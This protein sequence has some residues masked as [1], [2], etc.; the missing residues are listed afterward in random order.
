MCSSNLE[1]FWK[2][3][4]KDREVLLLLFFIIFNLL[5]KIMWTWHSICLR[6]WSRIETHSTLANHSWTVLWHRTST[7]H[8]NAMLV[9]G[10]L[11]VASSLHRI[12]SIN[13]ERTVIWCTSCG[14]CCLIHSSNKSKCPSILQLAIPLFSSVY[15][16]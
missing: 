15:P 2:C 12:H 11:V 5:F 3:F 1:L 7:A 9:S 13:N 10:I 16:H 6:V 4:H 8:A 14:S